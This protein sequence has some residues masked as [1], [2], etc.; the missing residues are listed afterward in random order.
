MWVEKGAVFNN[1]LVAG[2]SQLAGQLSANGNL[3]GRQAN[4]ILNEVVTA[5]SSQL[6][7]KQE[8]FGQRADLVLANPNGITCNGC[9]FINVN[10][11]TLAVARPT[12]EGGVL[13]SLTGSQTDALLQ[14]DGT[15]NAEGTDVL[16]LISPSAKLG[17]NVKGGQAVSILLGKNTVGCRQRSG[18]CQ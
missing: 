16:R 11:A 7:G 2:A 18:H 9:G 15:I 6:L 12:V 3:Q 13:K 8:I 4:V 10:Q 5:N 14:T 1:S 17:G